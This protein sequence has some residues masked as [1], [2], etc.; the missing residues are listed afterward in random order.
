MVS[1]PLTIK[2]AV[3]ISFFIL[4]LIGIVEV[5]PA[6]DIFTNLNFNHGITPS[7]SDNQYEPTKFQ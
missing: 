4:G 3:V 5:L 6:G 1:S 7:M 2:T